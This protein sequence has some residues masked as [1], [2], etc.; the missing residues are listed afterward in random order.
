MK[1]LLLAA[2]TMSA[3]PMLFAAPLT[4]DFAYTGVG[5]A[6][7]G[8][9]VTGNLQID[10]AVLETILA[11]PLNPGFPISD[12]ESL[13]LIVAGATSGNGT[14][15]AADFTGFTWWSAGVNFDFSQNLVGQG[16]VPGFGHEVPW[17]EGGEADTDGGDFGFFI[18]GLPSAAPSSIGAFALLVASSQQVVSLTSLQEEIVPE[19]SS[20]ALVL[21]GGLALLARMHLPPR[22]IH[23]NQ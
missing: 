2:L 16:L 3:V 21:I 11:N 23:H 6:G 15:S 12:L 10:S 5:S 8:A 9:T 13:T 1:N 22:T 17:G 18:G 7:A 14:F 4:F 19:P 20:T